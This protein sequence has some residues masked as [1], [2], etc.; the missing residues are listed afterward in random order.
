MDLQNSHLFE[1][2][3]CFLFFDDARGADKAELMAELN[4][5]PSLA[6]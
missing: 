4:S 3:A 6:H 2:M 1:D 5:A